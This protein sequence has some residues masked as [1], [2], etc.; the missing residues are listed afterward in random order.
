VNGQIT[1][2]LKLTANFSL[3]ETI[4]SKSDDENEVGNL[5]PNAPGAQ[6]GIWVKY[7]ILAPGVQ[8]LGIAVG[9]NF[10]SSRATFNTSLE[11]PAYLVADA[12]LYY[13]VDRFRISFN[14]N[15][16]FNEIHWTG[17]YDYNRLFPGTPR[18]F[19]FGIGYS[20]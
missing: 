5:L 7:S 19:M 2:N 15:N 13:S 8:G 9:T 12:A 11:L 4:I 20:F 16:I 6:G 18:N 14:L 3:N 17:G 1:D 10:V